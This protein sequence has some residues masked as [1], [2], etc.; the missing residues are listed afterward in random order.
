MKKLN[1]INKIAFLLNNIVA[2]LL[3]LSFFVPYIKPSSFYLASILGL[4]TPALFLLNILFIIYW[5]VIGFRKQFLLSSFVVLLSS[6]FATPIYKFSSNSKENDENQLKIMSYNVRK[7]NMYNWIDE[8]KIPEK[9]TSFIKKEDPDI[10]AL[11]EFKQDEN[12][13]LDYPYTYNHYSYN[14]FQ[15]RNVQSGLVIYSK[16]PIVNRGS[17]DRSKFTTDIIYAD[18]IKNNDT[19]RIYNFHLYSLGVVPDQ[20]N[21][22]HKDS[23]GL[24]K[25]LGISFKVQQKEIDSLNS[26]IVK[27]NYPTVLSCDMNNTAYSWVYRKTKK[28]L[29]DSFLESGNGFGKTYSFKGFPLRIDYIFVDPRMDVIQHKNYKIKYSD[30]YPIMATISF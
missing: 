11:Q 9:I 25:N 28:Q 16:Y 15:K 6:F 27:N 8:K 18:I 24:I 14:Y 4:A 17:L 20:D 19:L 2:I 7:F 21:F 30:H 1:F 5:I 3:L 22:G 26:H 12:F 23:E 13:K 10:V 29:K